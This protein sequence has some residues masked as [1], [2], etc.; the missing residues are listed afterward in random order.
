MDVRKLCSILLT[1]GAFMTLA[2]LLWWALF[3]GSV[4]RELGKDASLIDAVGCLYS[5]GGPCGFVAGL[6]QLGGKTPYSPMV[7]W[8]GV[9]LLIVG[10][11]MRLALKDATVPQE[12]QEMPSPSVTTETLAASL[13]PIAGVG[14]SLGA[15]TLRNAVLAVVGTMLI[16]IAGKFQVPFQPVPMTMQ[17]FV[18]LVLG[19]AY[20][21][22]LAGATILLY[23]AAGALGLPVFSGTPEKGIGLAYMQGAVGGYLVG[24]LLAALACGFLAERG[25][26][27]NVITTALAML[28]GN[29]IIYVP[30]LLWLGSLYGWDKPILEWGLTPFI[31]GDLTKLALAAAVLPLAWQLLGRRAS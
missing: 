12:V 2:A 17:T 6:A 16:W 3:Y 15:Q 19:M 30:G 26:D 25:W 27:R 7:F 18:I 28:I 31:L 1:L 29:V 20:G 4:V 14:G 21:W 22:Q 24:F 10:V 23:L 5:S 11:V 8:I 13:W 9:A